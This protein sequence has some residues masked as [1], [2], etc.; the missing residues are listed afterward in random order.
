VLTELLFVPIVLVYLA[1]L[2]ALFVYGMNFIYLTVVALRTG[3]RRP[4]ATIPETWPMVT[5]QL[6]V[7]NEYYVAG[8][9]IDAAARLDYPSDRLEIQVLDDSTDD[10]SMVVREL[11]TKWRDEGVDIVH[12]RRE[13]RTGYKAGALRYGLGT[14]R[15][16]LIA[17]FDADFVPTPGFLRDAVPAM[18]ADPGL[19]FVQARWGHVNREFSLLTRLQAV[20]IDGHFGIEQAGRWARGYCFNFNGTAGVWRRRALLDVGGWQDDTLTEDLDV[21]YRA[22]LA[23]WRAGYLR[24]VEAPAELPVSMSAYRRQQH[25]WARGSF[26]CAIKH[27]PTLWRSDLSFSRKLSA[28]LHLTGYFIHLLLLVLSLLYPVILLV[29]EPHPELFALLGVLGIFNLTTLAPTLMFTVGQRQVG[30]RWL[31]QLPTVL[32]LS[33]LGCGM[34]VNTARAGYQAVRGG[35]AAFERTPKFGIRDRHDDWRRLRYQLALDWIVYV[36]VGFAAL[37]ATTS[38][39]AFSG[40]L[41]VIGIYAAIFAIGLGTVAGASIRQALQTAWAQRHAA[42]APAPAN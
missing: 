25:R 16:E 32:V 33:V 19:A 11:V 23:G 24:E 27:L 13:G 17:I 37:N 36:E 30:R 12:V 22:F 40:G 28:T 7:Y 10:T 18:V 35:P 8:R 1:I 29:A 39:L 6:P 38:V 15:G 4:A 14:A 26:E 9:L 3:D 34:M 20:A 5:V 21:S 2:C 41:W 42:A 31:L